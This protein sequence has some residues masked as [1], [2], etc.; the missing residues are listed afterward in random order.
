[1]GPYCSLHWNTQRS[2][3]DFHTASAAYRAHSSLSGI[4][5]NKWLLVFQW[6]SAPQENGTVTE[7]MASSQSPKHA[8]EMPAAKAQPHMGGKSTGVVLPR[9]HLP[10]A[11]RRDQV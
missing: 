3:S 2:Q 9:G 6:P 10:I 1:M 7:A 4:T 11:R 8:A 5:Q